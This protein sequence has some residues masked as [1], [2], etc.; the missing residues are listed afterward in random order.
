MFWSAVVTFV[1]LLVFQLAKAYEGLLTQYA[2]ASSN[3]KA[4]GAHNAVLVA[5]LAK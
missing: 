1:V 3:A 5:H 4:V 2:A